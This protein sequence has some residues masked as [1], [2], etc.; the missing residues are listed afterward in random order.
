ML[1]NLPKI[2][3]CN[4]CNPSLLKVILDESIDFDGSKVFH[5]PQI[6]NDPKGI[7][8]GSM[9]FEYPKLYSDTSIFDDLLYSISHFD[10]ELEECRIYMK[11][12]FSL[13]YFKEVVKKERDILR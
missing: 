2:L 9:D 5:D 8:I 11:V 1:K 13:N 6:F 4:I 7:S 3:R 10:N 12:S